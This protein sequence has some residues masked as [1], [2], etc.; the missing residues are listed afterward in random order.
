M[1]ERHDTGS[2]EK[3]PASAQPS[4]LIVDDEEDLAR[5][6]KRVLVRRG[7]EVTT[8]NEGNA[9]LEL[10]K[11][12]T[13]DVILSSSYRPPFSVNLEAHGFDRHAL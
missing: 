1:G 8:A 5:A 2:F 10:L 6:L 4:V 12:R 9:A 3:P 13:F 11:Q 7:Y